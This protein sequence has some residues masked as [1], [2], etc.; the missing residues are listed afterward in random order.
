MPQGD[1]ACCKHR[2]PHL[3]PLQLVNVRRLAIQHHGLDRGIAGVL[4][5]VGALSLALLGGSHPEPW[6]QGV[7]SAG[8]GPRMQCN[9]P[10]VRTNTAPFQKELGVAVLG[11]RAVVSGALRVTWGCRETECGGSPGWAPMAVPAWQCP[12]S[13]ESIVNGAPVSRSANAYA[14]PAQSLGCPYFFV[15]FDKL[16]PCAARSRCHFGGPWARTRLLE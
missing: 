13:G 7:I 11:W 1:P 9:M 8:R 4:F 12:P 3:G 2:D 5:P 10:K 6:R 14:R 15:L 16:G